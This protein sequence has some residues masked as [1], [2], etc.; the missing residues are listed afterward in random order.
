MPASVRLL[1]RIV[2]RKAAADSTIP[3]LF[4]REPNCWCHRRHLLEGCWWRWPSSRFVSRC[5]TSAAER[6]P[7]LADTAAAD[8]DVV[9]ADNL[10]PTTC[11]P[12]EID[13][14]CCRRQ[15]T[16]GT[17]L[18]LLWCRRLDPA[19]AAGLAL[20][21]F[22][23]PSKRED[24]SCCSRPFESRRRRQSA[25]FVAACRRLSP[26]QASGRSHRADAAAAGSR[27]A[28]GHR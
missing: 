3:K 16:A 15:P 10:Q 20:V 7:A 28:S 11:R 19:A 23:W 24:C 17:S 5:R 4:G 2:A 21:G 13:C 1:Y 12:I 6:W 18:D 9:A 22:A 27:G 14:C 8:D 26:D 25:T